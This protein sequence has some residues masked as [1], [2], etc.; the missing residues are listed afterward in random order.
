MDEEGKEI[1]DNDTKY[2]DTYGQLLYE[3]HDNQNVNIIVEDANIDK[4]KTELK[5]AKNNG[6]LNDPVTNRQKM[7]VLGKTETEYSEAAFSAINDDNYRIEYRAAYQNAY[8]T[9]K[10]PFSITNIFHIVCLTFGGDAQSHI[11]GRQAGITEGLHDR[12][13]Q[14]INRF[15]PNCGFKNNI[16]IIKL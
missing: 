11:D 2:F 10:G 16:P 1:S 14:K 4:L 5:A 6:T 13:L 7:H 15:Y 8:T 12:K 3:T 9:G